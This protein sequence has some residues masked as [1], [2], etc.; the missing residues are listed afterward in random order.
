MSGDQDLPG[1]SQDPPPSHTLEAGVGWLTKL[2]QL[3]LQQ[4]CEE[5]LC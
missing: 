3:H 1:I 2:V 5:L 4:H